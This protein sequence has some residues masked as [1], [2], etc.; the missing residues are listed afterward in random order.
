MAQRFYRV[1]SIR[2]FSVDPD[3]FAIFLK[4]QLTFAS[5]SMPF[6]QSHVI[7][8]L[9]YRWCKLLYLYLLPW[10]YLSTSVLRVTAGLKSTLSRSW[11]DDMKKMRSTILCWESELWFYCHSVIFLI[12]YKLLI[13]FDCGNMTIFIC[14]V[15]KFYT[16]VVSMSADNIFRLPYIIG[17][18]AYSHAKTK[19]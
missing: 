19:S 7:L 11:G 2:F 14:S 10:H 15:P 1:R 12:V 17:H 13:F 18:S 4:V 16:S 3:I 6:I 5:F 9:A 8:E